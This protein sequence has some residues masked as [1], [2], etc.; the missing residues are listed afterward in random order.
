MSICKRYTEAEL[1]ELIKDRARLDWLADV[2]NS[3]GNAARVVA[4]EVC[5]MGLMR[6]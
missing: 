3:I 5:A 6:Q 2:N 1:Q 4:T